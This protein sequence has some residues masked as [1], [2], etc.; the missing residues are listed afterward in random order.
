MDKLVLGF[1]RKIRQ[2]LATAGIPVTWND[3]SA[4]AYVVV[5][6]IPFIGHTIFLAGKTIIP[7]PAKWAKIAATTQIMRSCNSYWY[8]T[9]RTLI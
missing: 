9:W 4:S 8:H 2:D 6:Y 3:S 5:K 1:Y 7:S